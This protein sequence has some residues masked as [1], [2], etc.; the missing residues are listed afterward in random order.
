MA[1]E[2]S[3]QYGGVMRRNRDK[4]PYL[5]KYRSSKLFILSTICM[6][7]FTDIFLYG[8]IVPVIPFALSE[9][10]SVAEKDIQKWVSVLL[11][12]YGAALLAFSPISGWFADQSSS[13]RWPL[14]LG[15]IALGGATVMLCVGNSI[16]LLLVGRALQGISAAVVWTVGLALLV[17]TVGQKGI[18]Q[19]MG[20]VTVSMSVGILI[21][22]L[23]GGVVYAHGGY[24]SVFAMAFALIGVDIFLRLVMIEKKVAAKWS[25]TNQGGS[26]GTCADTQD[27]ENAGG[28]A[29]DSEGSSQQASGQAGKNSHNASNVRSSAV[30]GSAPSLRET[31]RSAKKWKLPPIVT[32][33]KSRRLLSALFGCLVQAALMTSF[34]SVLPLYVH[35]I[36]HWGATAAGLIFL[37]A[38]LPSFVSPVVGFLSDK[39]GPR[40]LATIGFILALPFWVL[41]RLVDH[42]STGQKVLLCA[43]LAFIGFSL[44]LAMPPLMAEIT[45]VVEAKEKKYPGR[46]GPTGAYAQAYGLFNTAFAGGTLIGPVWSGF[47]EERAG[48]KTMSW[49]LGLLSGVMAV[50][51]VIWTGGSI[52]KKETAEPEPRQE[53]ITALDPGS[54]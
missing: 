31:T 34:D 14:V 13:R 20:Y 10:A 8:I 39:Y 1:A 3:Q 40:W 15:L 25:I 50:P 17:D 44:T 27:A 42:D 21:A 4:Q 47:I 5:L 54:A 23:L 2:K 29:Q 28:S 49:T 35:R 45:Y 33:L 12:V 48:W 36:F 11:A 32:L 41:L 38:V 16:A 46:F 53:E 51:I 19:A 24:Y 22:P 52:F 9:R 26:Y 18:G 6:A 43:L 30:E 37:P 7:V